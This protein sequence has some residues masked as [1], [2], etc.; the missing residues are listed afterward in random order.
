[1]VGQAGPSGGPCVI[2]SSLHV[3]VCVSSDTRKISHA[4]RNKVQINRETSFFRRF[5]T[6]HYLH[7]PTNPRV[8]R[9]VCTPLVRI[10]RPL[11]HFIFTKD[12]IWCE[13]NV[14][15]TGGKSISLRCCF[16]SSQL[17]SSSVCWR[18]LFFKCRIPG[19][20]I[21]FSLT[22]LV[23]SVRLSSG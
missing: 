8:L 4:F 23:V 6:L 5:F 1:M 15:V 9:A 22:K 11:L 3:R 12:H 10:F 18:T 17:F 2:R 19:E 7:A 14:N 13:I 20:C 21:A 16:F